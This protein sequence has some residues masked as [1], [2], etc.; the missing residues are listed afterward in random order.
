MRKV[1]K[2][3]NLMTQRSFVWFCRD[4]HK[5]L[6]IS[7]SLNSCTYRSIFGLRSMLILLVEYVLYSL[8]LYGI[9][10]DVLHF[11]KLVIRTQKVVLSLVTQK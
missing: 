2:I 8:H 1:L 7:C 6:L 10:I 11:N 9:H 3:I 5:D 4:Q